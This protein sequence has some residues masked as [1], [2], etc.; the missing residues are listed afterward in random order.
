MPCGNSSLVATLNSA[1][2]PPKAKNGGT[3]SERG[4]V[5]IRQNATK[6]DDDWGYPHGLGKLHDVPS[7]VIFVGESPSESSPG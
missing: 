7:R 4:R 3:P 5:F 6:I 1:A 2:D